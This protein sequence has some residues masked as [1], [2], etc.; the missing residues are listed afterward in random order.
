MEIDVAP[1]PEKGNYHHL[2]PWSKNTG[3]FWVTPPF[4]IPLEGREKKGELQSLEAYWDYSRTGPAY[5]P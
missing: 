3:I 4:L 5:T 2:H 1:L